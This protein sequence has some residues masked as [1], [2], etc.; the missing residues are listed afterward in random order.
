MSYVHELLKTVCSGNRCSA[1]KDDIL[2]GISLNGDF[3]CPGQPVA[4]E[5]SRLEDDECDTT[6]CDGTLDKLYTVHG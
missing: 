6:V 4:K 5:E 1:S 3:D 2:C